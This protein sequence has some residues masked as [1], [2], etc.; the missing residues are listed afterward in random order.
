MTNQMGQPSSP[1]TPQQ[2]SM[3]AGLFGSQGQVGANLGSMGQAFMGGPAY[4][5]GN[6]FTGDAYG[7]SANNPLPG[8]TALDYG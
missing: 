1:A 7:G 8:L 3:M 5:G 4:G 6:I 2:N